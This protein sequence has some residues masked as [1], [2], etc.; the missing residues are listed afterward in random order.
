MGKSTNRHILRFALPVSLSTFRDL[1]LYFLLISVAL[2]VASPASA[3]FSTSGHGILYTVES[4]EPLTNAITRQPDSSYHITS[5]ITIAD[6]TRADILRL[7]PGVT[8]RFAKGSALWI[9]GTLVAG[10]TAASPIIFTE[11]LL[12]V[13]EEILSATADADQPTS[14]ETPEAANQAIES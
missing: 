7:T 5:N 11:D 2:F 6:R 8:L 9:E 10:G 12:A 3:N 4:L 14:A 13:Q 1:L